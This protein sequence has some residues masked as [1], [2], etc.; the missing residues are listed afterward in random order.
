VWVSVRG[1]AKHD[2]RVNA[3]RTPGGRMMA[4]DLAAVAIRPKP[5]LI[6][7]DLDATYT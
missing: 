1:K 7:G 6:S 4:D 3:C 5:R 2:A